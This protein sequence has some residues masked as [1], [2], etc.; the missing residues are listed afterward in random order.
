M[1]IRN[2]KYNILK[3]SRHTSIER[4]AP[5]PQMRSHETTKF[6]LTELPA[7]SRVKE[8]AFT[9][10]ELL[11]VIAI[12]GILAAMMLPALSMAR[13]LARKSYCSNNMKQC[14]LSM[15]LYCNDYDSY[16]PPVHGVNPYTSPAA[17]TKEWWE[18]LI[19]YKMERKY[20][21][22]PDDPAVRNGF[23]AGWDQR[24]SYVINGMVAFGKKRSM[25]KTPSNFI[26]ISERNDS[27][28][29]LNH[30]GYPGFKAVSA[31][32]GDVKKERH[33]KLSNYT[34]I[35]GHVKDHLFESTIG[36]GTETQNKH[37]IN[38]YLD[39]YVP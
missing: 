30:Q 2:S 36:D 3:K 38:N 10:I 11:V 19:D 15:F 7:A 6:T 39:A 37:F 5:N 28:G 32:E 29:A 12:I 33:E 17:P 20:L 25:I 9:L 24:E 21:L 18:F 14:G 1:S 27:G 34:F 23:D 22:C 16:F 31:W 8:S 13:E 4:F 26:F 35:D